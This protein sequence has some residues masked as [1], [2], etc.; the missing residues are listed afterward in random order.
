MDQKTLYLKAYEILQKS[1]PLKFDCG[2]ICNKLCCKSIEENSGMYLFPGEEAMYE[3]LDSPTIIPS[4]F[5]TG[6]DK[7][8]LLALCYGNCDRNL[9][10]L[11]CRFFPLTPFI[12][13]KGILTVKI[14]P[15]AEEICPIA[16]NSDRSQLHPDF[17]KNARRISQLLIEDPEI[18]AFIEKLSG[19]LDEYANLPW[20]GLIK[21]R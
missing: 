15:R 4:G 9:R 12:T 17:V 10:P 3:G 16:R 5:Q 11:A 7:T 18:K 21:N 19:M 14:D 1:T 2:K 8:A 20:F 13:S 6:E